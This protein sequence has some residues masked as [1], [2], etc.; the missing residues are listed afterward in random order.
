MTHARSH[1][2]VHGCRN[3]AQP[4][5]CLILMI[6][7]WLLIQSMAKLPMK[8]VFSHK[9]STAIMSQQG[10]AAMKVCQGSNKVNTD[11]WFLVQIWRYT[12]FDVLHLMFYTLKMASNIFSQCEITVHVYLFNNQVGL[13]SWTAGKDQLQL[14]VNVAA[15]LGFA[16][17]LSFAASP[18]SPAASQPHAIVWPPGQLP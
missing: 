9:S 15:A 4:C 12:K 2:A 5:R 7:S 16:S 1:V 18:A 11:M 10:P 6:I 8:W 17:P 3:G 13:T 14:L